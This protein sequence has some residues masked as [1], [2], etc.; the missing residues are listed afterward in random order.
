MAIPVE[1]PKLG[2]TVE[3]CILAGWKK[4]KGDSVAEG[5]ILADIE[6]DKATFELPSPAGGTL[7]ELFFGAGSLVP[8]Y[9]NVC[10]IGDPGESVES[11][12]PAQTAAPAPA[13][14]APAPAASARAAAAVVAAPAAA[15]A[16]S[17]AAA[18]YVAP[19]QVF[20]SPRA[21]R[22]AQEHGLVAPTTPGSGPG[23]RVTEE[24]LR[25]IYFGS[26]RLSP[27]A[28]RHLEAGYEVR[29]G[30]TGVN[31]LV[32]A[33][34]LGEPPIR[35]SKIREM[36][37][38]R[39]R[40]SLSSTAQYTLH[41]SADATGLLA[42]RSKI[43]TARLS[44]P[45]PDIN[46]NDAVLFA[47]VK[48]LSQMPELNAELINGKIY[49]RSEVHLAFACDTDKGL[50][51]PVVRNCEK[52]S[53]GELAARVKEL[54]TRAQQGALAPD[55]LSG[56]TFTVSNLGN[57]GISSFTPII[58]PP[59]V[60]ILGVDS[61]ELKPVRREGRVEFV[62]HIGLSLTCDHQ[63][64]D[65]APGARFLKILRE[66]IENIESISELKL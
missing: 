56:A 50:L 40:E 1:M 7:L 54:T 61:I 65:G 45:I 66:Q 44:A 60:A 42:L 21:R 9:A 3:E 29:G 2:N 55:E 43:K 63:V 62:D 16:A 39:M 6:T 49:Q 31:H 35:M 26:P 20:L 33:R 38:R 52:A 37:A 53:I 58:S 23:G 5:E 22:F 57:L 46:I 10:V 25:R 36:T 30:G 48:A 34:D 41:T 19:P 12:R 17:P 27:L 14:R 28:R 59:Q 47:V 15:P 11:F 64:I 13:A 4:K 32:L 8:V 18:V 51:A 24:D